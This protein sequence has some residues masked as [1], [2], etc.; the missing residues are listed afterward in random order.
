MSTTN[1][2]SNGTIET[3]ITPTSSAEIYFDQDVIN[4]LKSR[5]SN[6]EL[7]ALCNYA[8]E[9]ITNY[10][11]LRQ[12]SIQ[13]TSQEIRDIDK[14]CK[15]II[16]PTI[17]Q[18]YSFYE[19]NPIAARIVELFSK[20]CWQ[21]SPSVYETEN[22]EE[23]T[24]F[25]QSIHNIA[26]QLR[27]QS[28]YEGD[29]DNNILWEICQKADE[30]SG[31]SHYGIILLGFDDVFHPSHLAKPVR[32]MELPFQE[33]NY[34]N[35]EPYYDGDVS[36]LPGNP[37]GSITAPN[38][39]NPTP[40]PNPNPNSSDGN[41]GI[42]PNPQQS[43]SVNP[44]STIPNP[45]GTVVNKLLFMRPFPEVMARVA[46]TEQNK[47]SPRYGFPKTYLVTFNDNREG[48]LSLVDEVGTT[49]TV[50]WTRVIHIADNTVSSPFLG[51]PRIKSVLRNIQDLEKEYA[52][53][54][55]GV[56]QQAFPK[57]SLETHPQLGGA[58]KIN[59]QALKDMLELVRNGMQKE[60]ILRGLTAKN[61]M[62]GV[63]DPSPYIDKAIEA[64]CI[65]IGCP[66]RIFKGSERGELAST[67]DDDA[68]NDR[69]KERQN[70]HCT[71]KIIV[72]IVDRLIQAKCIP[73]PTS[74]KVK[75]PD[76][77]SRSKQEKATTAVAITT[78]LSSYKESE[79][80]D[81]VGRMDFYT[82]VLGFTQS[83]AKEM[84]RNTGHDPEVTQSLDK[85]TDAN[86]F[87]E[88]V[89]PSEDET[90]EESASTTPT[91]THPTDIAKN[92]IPN[93]SNKSYQ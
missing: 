32:G 85:L 52:S 72:P 23:I 57:M 30:V 68:W 35:P 4:N 45:A 9:T 28:W 5:Y 14:E 58:V 73:E 64:I 87:E 83:E 51:R 90:I 70:R 31:I 80:E 78:A 42:V 74:F 7:S 12:S 91:P 56:W 44:S 48:S 46:S 27:G 34:L 16:N 86:L 37:D 62:P 71:P 55:E 93:Q 24:G 84:L 22:E 25:E 36:S 76:L 82:K 59:E 38:Y 21:V 60:M 11:S 43:K 88:E 8:R 53:T 18:Y 40:I 63:V 29:E 50:H 3:P 61:L 77:T 2:E 67:Q 65:K 75:W 49:C 66:I 69:I 10:L 89:N 13:R 33:S 39:Y 26:N 41:D 81:Y 17:E 19:N 15:Y 6:N 47:L 1:T 20:E 54:A 79:L 92:P